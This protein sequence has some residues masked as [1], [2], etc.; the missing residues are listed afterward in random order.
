M[1]AFSD[2]PPAEQSARLHRMAL[3]AVAHWPFECTRIEPLKVREN[4]VYAVHTTD[5]RRVAQHW[6]N[7]Y[8]EAG[9]L[10]GT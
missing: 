5:G 3:A 9:R 1:T 4:A 8:Q 7:K 10:T 2:L 6:W